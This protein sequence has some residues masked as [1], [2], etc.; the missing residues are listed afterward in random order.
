MR[1]SHFEAGWAGASIVA[2]AGGVGGSRF[3]RGLRAAT[4]G[5]HIA[6]IVNTGD[7]VTLHGLRISPDIDTVL[8]ALAGL[9]NEARG[10][11]PKGDTFRCMAALDRLGGETWFRLGDLD[12]ATHLRRRELLDAGHPPSA[13]TRELAA[14]L[15]ITGVEI[16]PMTDDSVETWVQLAEDERWV[17]FQDYF[18]KHRAGVAIRGV[19]FEGIECARPAPGVVDALARADLVALC[20]SNPLVSLD[21]IL[22]VPGVRDGV[23]A[24]RARGA[25]VGGVSPLIGGATVKGPAARMLAELGHEPSAAGV[26][27]LYA[28]LLEVYLLDRADAELGEA[29]ERLGVRPVV[30]DGLMRGQRGEA[31]LARVFLRACLG[32]P[33]PA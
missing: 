7:D 9:V 22:G 1:G 15:G 11:G 21:P 12:L 27:G 4:P 14:R 32:S 3:L 31:R 28:D 24:A 23:R 26:A 17:H 2:M 18:V 5:A 16:L 8:Y 19:R 30:T 10:W 33:R 25:V 20:P 13:V 6:A 29:V